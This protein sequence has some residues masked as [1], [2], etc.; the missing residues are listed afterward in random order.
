MPPMSSGSLSDTVLE[1]AMLDVPADRGAAYEV[2]FREAQQHLEAS[3]GYLG[4][5]LRSRTEAPGRYVLLVWWNSLESH[6]EGFRGSAGY[7]SWKALLHPFYDPF[8]I[9][10]HFVGVEGAAPGPT[11]LR[12]TQEK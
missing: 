3:P 2:A 1:I 11:P 8:P 9:V 7:Q 4:H 10:E 6:T 12:D 5:E